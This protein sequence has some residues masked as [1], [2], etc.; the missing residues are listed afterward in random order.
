MTQNINDKTSLPAWLQIMLDD[1]P[2]PAQAVIETTRLLERLQGNTAPENA[3]S[4]LNMLAQK[5]RE[6]TPVL[7]AHLR[8]EAKNHAQ[9]G[10][11]NHVQ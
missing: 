9:K 7:S 8:I 3:A 5:Y 11:Q 6:D 2:R 10:N 1:L 4:M